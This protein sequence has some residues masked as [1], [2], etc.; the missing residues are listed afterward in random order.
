MFADLHIH[1]LLSGADWKA[2]IAGHQPEPDDILIRNRLSA[3]KSASISYLRDSSI[4]FG[5][6]LRARNCSGVRHH[7]PHPGVSHLQKGPLRQLHRTG[8]VRFR[9][10][11]RIIGRGKG[12]GCGL[13]SS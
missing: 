6:C 9:G 11:P 1:M 5:V 12:G 2:A 7:L 10:I 8:M 3:Y 13:S 4:R